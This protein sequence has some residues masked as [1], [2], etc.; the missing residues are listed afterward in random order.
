METVLFRYY[1]AAIIAGAQA[2]GHSQLGASAGHDD[3]LRRNLLDQGSAARAWLMAW[4]GGTFAE[5]RSVHSPFADRHITS[6]PSKAGEGRGHVLDHPTKR[7]TFFL[8][9]KKS[10]GWNCKNGLS[11]G[12]VLHAAASFNLLI[13]KASSAYAA[14]RF[15]A[16]GVRVDT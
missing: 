10:R 7:L 15:P 14:V 9:K 16:R 13:I 11:S 8:R 1:Q 2:G 4:R 3:P 5:D 6:P 12:W